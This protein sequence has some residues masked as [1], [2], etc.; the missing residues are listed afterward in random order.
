MMEAS[1]DIKMEAS[2][3]GTKMEARRMVGR[4][5]VDEKVM[6]AKVNKVYYHLLIIQHNF[7]FSDLWQIGL[8]TQFQNIQII[9]YVSTIISPIIKDS[10]IHQASSR[11]SPSNRH[12]SLYFTSLKT[13]RD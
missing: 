8:T 2:M 4:K 12:I 5:Q 10:P 13:H 1:M 7:K 3:M 9:K 6:A 11:I